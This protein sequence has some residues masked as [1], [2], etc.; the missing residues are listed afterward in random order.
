MIALMVGFITIDF[1][2]AQYVPQ[3]VY[4]VPIIAMQA[5]I[6]RILADRW[7]VSNYVSIADWLPSKEAKK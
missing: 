7:G 2:L 5:V 3:L 6:A 1:A 4:G